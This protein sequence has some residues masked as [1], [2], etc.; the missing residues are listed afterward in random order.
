MI[1]IRE[2]TLADVAAREALLD[3][4]FGDGA[5]PQDLRAPARGPPAGRR[6]SPSSPRWTARVVGTVR[7]WHVDAGGAA[8]AAARAARGRSAAARAWAS[9]AALMRAALARARRSATRAVLL[10][11]DAPYYER[12]GFSAALTGALGCRARSSASA[13]SA[14]N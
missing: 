6:A 8:G 2:E 4:C 5:L 12:F 9:A 13:S 11:G 1:A 7:L 3:R 10:V 14:W